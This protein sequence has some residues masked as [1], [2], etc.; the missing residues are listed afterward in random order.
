VFTAPA[1]HPSAFAAFGEGSWIV[2]PANVSGSEFISVGNKVVFLEHA[3][4]HV[5]D[6]RARPQLDIGDG[7]WFGRFASITCEVAISIGDRVASSDGA[8]IT[9]TWRTAWADDRAEPPVP[10][11]PVVIG[12][13][14]YL[15]FNCLITP[16]VSIGEGAFVGEGAVVWDDVPPHAVVYG[17]PARVVRRHD[18][19]RGWVA[20]S[21]R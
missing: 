7:C 11:A 2:P 12:A 13:G 1:P 5:L 18:E 19:Q 10:A 16:G 3:S 21:A 9:D 20:A 4:I 15:G 8:C 6:H 14:A 17:N